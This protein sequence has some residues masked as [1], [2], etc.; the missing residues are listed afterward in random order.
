[1]RTFKFNREIMALMANRYGVHVI[2][3]RDYFIEAGMHPDDFV[4]RSF[5]IKADRTIIIGIYNNPEKELIS[6]FHELAHILYPDY[7][8]RETW[9]EGIKIAE[10]NQLIFDADTLKW[11]IEQCDS[12]KPPNSKK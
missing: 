10:R 12:Y 9:R 3:N 5:S 11:A 4:D 6:F 7:N 8:E 1:M 2:I